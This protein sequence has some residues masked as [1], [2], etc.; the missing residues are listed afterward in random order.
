MA[1]TRT[2]DQARMRQCDSGIRKYP[3]EHV[4][5]EVKAVDGAVAPCSLANNAVT[6][7]LRQ[8]TVCV[9]NEPRVIESRVL[10]DNGALVNV[11]AEDR[12]ESLPQPI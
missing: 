12:I 3:T 8:E 9:S 11:D 10:L 6:P 2:L 1:P 5:A 7:T 4:G